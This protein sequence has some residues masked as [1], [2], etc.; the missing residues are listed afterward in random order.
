MT[1][2]GL[3]RRALLVA[4]PAD[5][6]KNQLSVDYA[7]NRV[8]QEL[9]DR[10]AFDIE[11]CVGAR[12]TREGILEALGA[13]VDRCRADDV[14]VCVFYYFGHGGRVQFVDLP[15]VIDEV[16][17]YV[18]CRRVEPVDPDGRPSF[19]GVL[20]CELS[21]KL[22]VLAEPKRSVV[23]LLDCC[24]AGQL[25]RG[26]CSADTL[27]RV[28]APACVRTF[29]E[30][31]HAELAVDSH[32]DIV[33]LVGSTPKRESFVRTVEQGQ[34]GFMTHALLETLAEQRGCRG[35]APSLGDDKDSL[36]GPWGRAERGCRGTAPSLGDDKD[37]KDSLPASW[38]GVARRVRQL[39]IDEVGE[40]QWVSFAGPR[41]RLLFSTAD[42]RVPR[43]VGL[44]KDPDSPSH[45]WL[46][47]GGLQG[48]ELGDQWGVTSPVHALGRAAEPLAVGEV[49]RVD[50]NRACVE[51]AAG[52]DVGRLRSNA[53]ELVAAA[54]RVD[55]ETQDEA[56]RA[57]LRSSAWLRPV[58]GAQGSA[59][60]GFDEPE[61]AIEL[62]EDRARGERLLSAL[63]G[64]ADEPSGR[65][66]EQLPVAWSWGVV[67]KD[68]E[69]STSRAT[70]ASEARIWL[71]FES[72]WPRAQRWF[73][74]VI[75][76]D[77]AGRPWQLNARVPTGIELERGDRE[78]LG[79]RAGATEAGLALPGGEGGVGLVSGRAKIV[80]VETP[81][82][83][84][85]GHLVCSS[86]A[87][88]IDA[89]AMQGLRPRKSPV[90]RRRGP[91]LPELVLRWA[92]QIV[93]LEIR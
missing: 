8:A 33:R 90:I 75:Y 50:L 83:L 39:V 21:A 57:R 23:A 87:S 47:V 76:I 65:C 59:A 85:F 54:R 58:V 41:E 11:R 67:G 4:V 68:E 27:R 77:V 70:L 56:S 43:T 55:V 28:S 93:D 51:F 45:A 1:P 38:D 2:E 86:R 17:G 18:T 81:R 31:T 64:L 42:A 66:L 84:E 44:V 69:L 36:P 35:T 89:Y 12:A 25:V 71:K 80:V 79:L 62:L 13:W 10:F 26:G 52:V 7:V 6:G 34:I 72:R 78:L 61:G 92:V 37:S 46:R 5:D 29:F 74:N 22:S 49:V 3:R 63:R 9:E 88:S 32:P 91:Q 60:L 82:P 16:F 20:G 30:R 48:V 73:V 15:A 40:G 14:D 19:E 24:Y 53:A